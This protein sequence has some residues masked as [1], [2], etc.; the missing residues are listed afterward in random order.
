MTMIQQASGLAI[1]DPAARK[2]PVLPEG[3]VHLFGRHLPCPALKTY[4]AQ[5]VICFAGN[6]RF[7]C[8]ELPGAKGSGEYL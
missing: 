7:F 4:Q 2:D 8:S 5:G 1:V 6:I 3:L